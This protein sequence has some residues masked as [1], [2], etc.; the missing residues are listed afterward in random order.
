MDTITITREHQFLPLSGS[1]QYFLSVVSIEYS[2]QGSIM[3]GVCFLILSRQADTS[4]W[5]F[6]LNTIS[7]GLGCRVDI[8]QNSDLV[9]AQAVYMQ[10]SIFET[11]AI[12][13]LPLRLLMS[14]EMSSPT[15]VKYFIGGLWGLLPLCSNRL[16]NRQRS[17]FQISDR[18]LSD[19]VN[20]L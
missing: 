13:V 12:L 4:I 7:R 1:F 20:A 6:H 10:Q 3:S 11:S 9:C 14:F 19:N 2:E 8:L 5:K 18:S 16:L 17:G 15:G